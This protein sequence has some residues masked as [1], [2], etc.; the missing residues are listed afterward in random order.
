MRL[1]EA[2]RLGPTPRLALVGSGGKSTALFQL[3]RE[4]VEVHSNQIVLSPTVLLVA[5]TH[6][7]IE[8][9]SLADRHIIMETVDDITGLSTG[10]TP[11]LVLLTGPYSEEGRTKGMPGQLMDRLYQL[12]DEHCLPLLIEANGSRKKPLKAPAEYEPVIPGYVDIVVVVAGLSGIGKPLSSQWVHRPERFGALASLSEGEPV[13]PEAL[14]KVL[15]DPLGGLKEIPPDAR[16]VILLNQADTE[17]QQAMA[18]RLVDYLLPNYHSVVIAALNP[19][20]TRKHRNEESQEKPSGLNYPGMECVLAAHEPV[21]GIVLAA[22]ASSR[23][24]Q[25]KQIMPWRG[26]P[27]VRRVAQTALAA[28][29]S[30]VV[31]ITGSFA[32]EVKSVVRDLPVKIVQNVKWEEGQSSSVITGLNVLPPKT[33]AAVFLLADQPQIPVDLVRKLREV[34]AATLS[35]IVAP[36]VGDRRANPV[37]FD[38]LTFSTLSSLKG[39]VGGRS[40]FSQYP[41]TWIP[42]HDEAITLDIDTLDDYRRLLKLQ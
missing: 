27:I 42:W 18:A 23:M 15:T 4:L 35:P 10:L 13:T 38:R 12:V 3:G 31:V 2:L 20:T 41:V 32:E 28:G 19:P 16:R 11:G 1:K 7:C 5:T 29:L 30:P 33:G 39:D 36:Q 8:Q 9:L 37:L 25:V 14:A 24:G 6:M 26:E 22:G 21:A 40:L 17:E 34:H